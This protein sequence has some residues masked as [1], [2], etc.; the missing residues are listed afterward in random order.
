MST[1]DGS[2]ESL[3]AFF[4]RP[5]RIYTTVW[6]VNGPLFDT[7]DPWT[8]FWTNKR[9]INRITNYALLRSRL[10]VAFKING[11]SFYFGRA[12][13]SYIP[14]RQS[15]NMSVNRFFTDTDLVDASQ[16]P[17]VFLD[18]TTNAGGEIILPFFYFKNYMEVVGGEWSAL[19]SINIRS[20]QALKTAN[21][22][23]RPVTVQVYAWASEVEF[24]L[25][26]SIAATG[27]VPQA[28]VEYDD[29]AKPDE[30]SRDAGILST[31]LS[32]A[33]KIAG[34]FTAAPIIGP[35]AK[36]TQMAAEAG[37]TLAKMFG[38]SRPVQAEGTIFMKDLYVGNMA[39][40]NVVDN[41]TK[42]AFDIKQETTIDS[43]IAGLDGTDEMAI[44]SLGMRPSYLTQF[45]WN[46][47]GVPGTLLFSTVV[48]PVMFNVV[49]SAPNIEHHFSPACFASQLFR[50]W[51]GSF[52]M[53]LQFV[54]S[55]YHKGRVKIVW[56]PVALGTGIP[57]EDNLN[58][59]QVVDLAHTRDVT[60]RVPW[61]QARHWVEVTNVATRAGIPLFSTTGAIVPP[62]GETNGVLGVYVLNDLTSPSADAAANSI[63]VNV[64]VSMCEDYCLMNPTSA[65]ISHATFFP[66]PSPGFAEMLEPQAQQEYEMDNECD[67]DDAPIANSSCDLAMANMHSVSPKFYEIYPGEVVDSLR[68]V[69]K[70]FCYHASYGPQANVNGQLSI[71]QNS[72]PYF[73]GNA[74]GAIGTGVAPA[75]P[76]NMCGQTFLNYIVPAFAGWR[77][78]IR[79]KVINDSVNDAANV[80]A[81]GMA[82]R[83]PRPNTTGFQNTYLTALNTG[84]DTPI[85]TAAEAQSRYFSLQDG[86]LRNTTMDGIQVARN[87][88][89]CVEVEL[90]WYPPYRFFP[91]K[92][93]DKT[94]LSTNILYETWWNFRC[95]MFTSS[96]AIYTTNFYCGVAEDFNAFFFTGLP[97]VFYQANPTT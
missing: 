86:I 64:F 39:N 85:R 78:G 88:N 72:F 61:G 73:R 55:S 65:N 6:A 52:E 47:T 77:G 22:S 40:S 35:Y 34:I 8:L 59:T 91:A 17:H 62:V 26:T 21:G 33:S 46:N 42:L 49:G 4:A 31:P 67:E 5:I 37:S 75:T 97:P 69:L 66:L 96:T 23:T 28:L 53:R 60:V 58:Y 57:T 89:T 30:Y 3:Q 14:L 63:S 51:H 82:S 36:A 74:P 7:F 80:G 84:A 18:P 81:I 41:S 44:A 70:R 71:T 48:S 1:F 79:W 92:S 90:P 12:L 93:S 50:N 15:D 56:D 76:W 10:H 16:R 32:T 2:N 94:S 13:A 29:Q 11:N 24:G 68:T 54:A 43:R 9:N 19:G 20:M 83:L 87:N 95:S 38:F 45:V 25:P 27:L